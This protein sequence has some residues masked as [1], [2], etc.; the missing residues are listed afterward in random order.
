[1]IRV[2]DAAL[3]EVD[4]LSVRVHFIVRD[5]SGDGIR[6]VDVLDR[7]RRV[8]IHREEGG[9]AALLEFEVVAS[10]TALPLWA[11]G[12]DCAGRITSPEEA[13]GPFVV[14]GPEGP[15]DERPCGNILLCLAPTRECTEAAAALASAHAALASKCRECAP[16]RRQHAEAERLV[17]A[18]GIALLILFAAAAVAAGGGLFGFVTF[19]FIMIIVAFVAV[20]LVFAFQAEEALRQRVERC[21]EEEAEARR[22]F[23]VACTAA[24]THCCA[25]CLLTPTTPPC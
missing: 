22:R 2:L 12:E 19:V 21:D 3:R 20:Q 14:V 24:L 11:E 4:A 5:D 18:L 7:E 23:E 9:C 8:R 6:R 13:G 10:R 15:T 25:D 17:A 1:M 16:L